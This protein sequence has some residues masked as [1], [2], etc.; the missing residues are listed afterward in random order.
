M[1]HSETIGHEAVSVGS[2]FP[3]I[4]DLPTVRLSVRDV[5]GTAHSRFYAADASPATRPLS[6]SEIS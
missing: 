4:E 1:I 2:L 5:T 3:V 6:R